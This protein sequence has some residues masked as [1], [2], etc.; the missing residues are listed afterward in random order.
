MKLGPLPPKP[1]RFP[2]GLF[3]RNVVMLLIANVVIIGANMWAAHIDAQ[4][5]NAWALALNCTAIGMLG[6]ALGRLLHTMFCV[7]RDWQRLRR[8][9]EAL[10]AMHEQLERKRQ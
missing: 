1:S 7:W 3:D 2:P 4:D 9:W 6:L 5:D 10:H 8:S